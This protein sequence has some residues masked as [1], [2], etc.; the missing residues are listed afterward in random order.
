MNT[1]IPGAEFAP[2]ISLG[3]Q[4]SMLGDWEQVERR[5]SVRDPDDERAIYRRAALKLG[6][7]PESAMSARFA[8]QW[9]TGIGHRWCLIVGDFDASIIWEGAREVHDRAVAT[10]ALCAHVWGPK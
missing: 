10:G 3:I 8:W 7:S 6:A 4:P 1:T 2:T 5:L 9:T